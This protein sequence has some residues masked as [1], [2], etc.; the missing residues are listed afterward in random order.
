M[1][2]IC[3]NKVLIVISCFSLSF[4]AGCGGGSS[5]DGY[6]TNVSVETQSKHIKALFFGVGPYAYKNSESGGGVGPSSRW[7]SFRRDSLVEII[8]PAKTSDVDYEFVVEEI[9][10]LNTAIAGYF[11]LTVILSGK[12][13]LTSANDNQITVNI[14]N[15]DVMKKNCGEAGGGCIQQKFYKPDN[16]FIKS[17]V[18]Y[19]PTS[20][21]IFDIHEIGHGIGLSDVNPAAFP[22]GTMASAGGRNIPKFSDS[23]LAAI[24]RVF[25]SGLKVG[26]TE[27][28]FWDAGLIP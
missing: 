26:A 12:D 15:S 4:L 24:N 6:T 18:S 23:E 17:G 14:V 2:K 7:T 10:R 25:T 22:E 1:K 3:L 11:T 28:D 20:E 16:H 27:Q 19:Y 21:G 5:D 13:E 8:L 9:D